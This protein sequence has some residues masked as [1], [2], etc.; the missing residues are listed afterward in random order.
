MAPTTM[1]TPSKR[2]SF[3]SSSLGQTLDVVNSG[4]YSRKSYR[5][6]LMIRSMSPQPSPKQSIWINTPYP[7]LAV[8]LA[9][10]L[11]Q[12]MHVYTK[13]NPDLEPAAVIVAAA[14][15]HEVTEALDRVRR[16]HPG[17]P[18]LLFDTRIELPLARAALQAGARGFIHAG[19]TP[20]QI[21]RAFEVAAAGDLAV[22][23]K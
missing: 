6:L 18:V 1:G 10:I 19:M 9:Q 11:R 16:T 22:P 13:H 20:Q 12:G 15:I 5:R 3:Q 8:G 14:E 23:R 21:V 2:F 7:T 4:Q 17:A